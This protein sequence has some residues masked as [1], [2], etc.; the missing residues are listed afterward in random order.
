[1]DGR[2]HVDAEDL[3]LDDR[4]EREVVKDLGAV[5]P[6]IDASVFAQTLAAGATSQ[7]DAMRPNTARGQQANDMR[8]VAIACHACV[9]HRES[10]KRAHLVVKAV[11]LSDL[12]RLVVAADEGDAVRVA[13][14]R[15]KHHT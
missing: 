2:A 14:L 4:R 3:V 11:D 15:T 7:R 12:P 10:W 5:A 1:M 6:N 13:H 8:N 9:G